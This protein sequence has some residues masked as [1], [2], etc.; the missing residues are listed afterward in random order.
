MRYLEINQEIPLDSKRSGRIFLD[1]K[2]KREQRLRKK[3]ELFFFSSSNNFLKVEINQI[4]Y[5]I[6]LNVVPLRPILFY[7]TQVRFCKYCRESKC[8]EINLNESFGG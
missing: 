8:R 2:L 3:E 7:G 5:N 1:N 6:I 4:I